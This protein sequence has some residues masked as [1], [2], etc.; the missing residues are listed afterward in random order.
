MRKFIYLI[1]VLLML[2]VAS[3]ARRFGLSTNLLDYVSLGTMNLDAAYATSRHWSLTAG[4]RYN[5]FTF[6][7]GDPDRQFQYRQQS[8]ALGTRYW[9]WHTWSGWW[10]AGK[11]RYQE[12]NVG[13]LWKSETEEGDR[14]GAGLYLGYDC[15]TS[16]H[17]IRSGCLGWNFLVY[18]I[19]MPDM[20]NNFGRRTEIFCQT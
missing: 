10:F 6:R 2:P 17:G 5:P 18:T 14:V 9:L 8:Y 11:A 3:H 13:G 4:V 12:Y 15:S 16:E 7:S 1:L 20:R 19:F